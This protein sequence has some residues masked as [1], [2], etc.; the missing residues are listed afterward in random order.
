MKA[1][2][3]ELC[4]LH[5]VTISA[6][7]EIIHH[8][9]Y[10]PADPD[11]VAKKS[12][13]FVMKNCS[14]FK[15]KQGI[16]ENYYGFYFQVTNRAGLSIPHIKKSMQYFDEL[17]FD[18][19]GNDGCLAAIYADMG[20]NELRDFHR[21]R[22]IERARKIFNA[23]EYVR[24]N[25]EGGENIQYA[26]ILLGRIDNLCA[27][28]DCSGALPEIHR[29]WEEIKTITPNS[30]S[31]IVPLKFYLSIIQYFTLAGDTVFARKLFNECKLVYKDYLQHGSTKL[32]FLLIEAQILRAEGKHKEAATL[33]QDWINGWPKFTGKSLEANAFRMAGLAQEFAQNYDLAIE[34]LENITRVSENLRTTFEV[35][36]RG[37]FF[38]GLIVESYWGLMRSYAARY[39]KERNEKDF[40]NALRVERM[41]RARQFGELVA[42]N[43][44]GGSFLDISNI[45][46]Q[47]DEL[48]LDYVLTD[49]AI[50]IFAIS[51]DQHDLF[52]IPYNAKIF[53]TAITQVRKQLS[54]PAN[55]GAL[56]RDLQDISKTIIKPIGDRLNKAKKLIVMSDGYLNGIPF[57]ILSKSEDQYYPLIKDYEVS[58]TPSISYLIAQRNANKKVSYTKVLFA[59]AD[60]AFGS[61]LVPEAYRDDT[62]VFYTRAVRDF[63]LFTPLPETRIEV[64]KISAILTST[65]ATLLFGD[66]ASKSIMKSTPMEG[67][68]YLHFATHGVL[69][70]QIPGI[71][72]PALVLAAG[73]SAQDSFLTLSE[74]EQLKLN[75]DLTVLSA[76]DT[77]SGKYYTGEGVMGMSRGFLVAG[78]QSVLASLWPIDSKSTVEFMILFYLH[79]QSGKSKSESLRL[80]QLKFL[81]GNKINSSTERGVRVEDKIHQQNDLS[82]PYYWTSFVL[83]GE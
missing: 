59:M 35:R 16:A 41:L 9:D 58:M 54:M 37:Q 15:K 62:A 48:L 47:P 24:N 40:Q 78:S 81:N 50:V 61:P 75:S 51:S 26:Q 63:N 5:T 11:A 67:Y 73:K 19:V 42:I 39:L 64:E 31:S 46:L 14:A 80:A 3:E 4:D 2:Q 74:I 27:A 69:G 45:R 21:I 66:N 25:S 68:R 71:N 13:D 7:S 30:G 8:H 65:N 55:I 6:L 38:S 44:K 79:L 60:P 72:E 12:Y 52:L 18:N 82:H 83:T 1:S 57:A 32:D 20:Q 70:N 49:K 34:Y 10:A 36:S 53:N 23:R 29:L 22:A 28:E 77:G 76:C 43:Q 56:Y 33:W 17:S